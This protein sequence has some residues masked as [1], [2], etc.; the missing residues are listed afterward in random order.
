MSLNEG[1]NTCPKRN[2]YSIH[3]II[4]PCVCQRLHFLLL[5]FPLKERTQGHA[6]IPPTLGHLTE[7]FLS[8]SHSCSSTNAALR[9]TWSESLDVLIK[10]I[11]FLLPN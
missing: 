10:H 8:C 3:I 7:Y 2:G 9:P 4:F 11:A 5:F 6:I 1:E